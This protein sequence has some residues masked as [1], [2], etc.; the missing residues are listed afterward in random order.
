MRIRMVED[1]VAISHYKGE[2]Q[3][4]TH[5]YHGHEAIASIICSQLSVDDQL[6][7]YYR[8]H[9]WY[10]AKGGDL[11]QLVAELFGK[12]TGCCDGFGGSMHLLALKS[13]FQGTISTVAGAI[14]HAVGAALATKYLGRESIVLSCFGDGATEE[15]VFQESLMFSALH[16]LP[17]VFVCE[18]NGLACE[19]TISK[20]QPPVEIVERARAMGV[21]AVQVKLGDDEG[22]HAATETALSRARAGEGP[23]F[24][25]CIVRRFAAH[26]EIP[27]ISPRPA[28]H[29]N[30]AD[31][32]VLRLGA[33]LT[34]EEREAIV[35]DINVE[36]ESAIEF[37]R[38]SPFPRSI[39]RDDHGGEYART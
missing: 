37:A 6:F 31:D 22:L 25:E 34:P 26:C 9:G 28:A 36:L 19:T 29:L 3:T 11:R 10:L 35:T 7:A 12:A 13:G 24:I 18:N 8:S 39:R 4:P 27:G 21:F 30:A 23:S 16:K 33:C 5:L 15:G 14:P 20:R 1:A 17:I 38:N 32:P 2:I